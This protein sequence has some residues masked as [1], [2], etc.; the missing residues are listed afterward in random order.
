MDVSAVVGLWCV[1]MTIFR[2]G[3]F[4]LVDLTS[5][6][7]QVRS[8]RWAWLCVSTFQFSIW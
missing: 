2:L 7:S 6:L 5:L 3:S 4:A 1:R 8:V